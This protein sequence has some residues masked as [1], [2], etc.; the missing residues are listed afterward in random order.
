MYPE[1]ILK[2]KIIQREEKEKKL[3]KNF[4]NLSRDDER[5]LKNVS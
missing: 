2:G 5:T 1:G 3:S 4:S